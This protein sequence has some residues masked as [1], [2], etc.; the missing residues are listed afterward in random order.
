MNSPTLIKTE[1]VEKPEGFL[2]LTRRKGQGIIIHGMVEIYVQSIKGNTA[3]LSIK[4]PREIEIMRS[5][6]APKKQS[7]DRSGLAT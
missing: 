7:P 1:E 5:E 6:I 3:I 4:A 2:V